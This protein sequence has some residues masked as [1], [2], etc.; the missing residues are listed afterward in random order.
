[1]FCCISLLFFL[2]CGGTKGNYPVSGKVT[3]DGKPVTEGIIL[4]TSSNRSANGSLKAD[5]SFT[6]GT[7]KE[8]DGA[9]PGQY[10]I[11]FSGNCLGG[12]YENKPAQIN[13]K[14]GNPETSGL[15]YEVKVGSNPPA[16]FKLD[17]P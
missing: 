11:S 10:K 2:G 14:Y 6:L 8:G 1:L 15:T 3:V 9:L 13:A 5:G 12:G 16:E 4:F 7:E 17:K